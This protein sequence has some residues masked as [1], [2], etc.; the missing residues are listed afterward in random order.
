MSLCN[1]R[2]TLIVVAAGTAGAQRYAT[3]IGLAYVTRPP[4]ATQKAAIRLIDRVTDRANA[5][6]A[7]LIRV[8]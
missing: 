2:H 8:F 6:D 3:G 7:R 4:F 1:I 5:T